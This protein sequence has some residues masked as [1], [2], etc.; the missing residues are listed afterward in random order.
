MVM[1]IIWMFHTNIKAELILGA[2][3]AFIIY[4]MFLV[5]RKIWPRVIE[6]DRDGL[7]LIGFPISKRWKWRDVDKI[8]AIRIGAVGSV[9]VWV[10]SSSGRRMISLG[11]YWKAGDAKVV[12]QLTALKADSR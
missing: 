6:A 4:L 5:I 1:V 2:I 3:L 10:N 9:F 12:D 8:Q 7:S 11:S